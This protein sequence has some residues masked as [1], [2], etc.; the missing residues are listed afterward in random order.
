MKN[1]YEDGH[2]MIEW[3]M[4]HSNDNDV[5]EARMHFVTCNRLGHG[6]DVD[7]EWIDVAWTMQITK[8]KTMVLK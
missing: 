6:L 1:L 5:S 7:L 8:Y 3:R 4:L 2:S